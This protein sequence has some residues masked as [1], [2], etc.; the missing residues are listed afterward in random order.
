MESRDEKRPS[1]KLRK[2]RVLTPLHLKK[3]TSRGRENIFF[4]I[5]LLSYEWL[6]WQKFLSQQNKLLNSKTGY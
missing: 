3:V 1:Q 5:S 6:N 4:P 2:S